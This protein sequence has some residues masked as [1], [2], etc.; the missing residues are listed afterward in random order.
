HRAMAK[1]D[2]IEQAQKWGADNKRA[3]DLAHNW[4]ANISFKRLGGV[5][6]VERMSGLP[7]G[8]FAPQCQ[9]APNT[10]SYGAN[11]AQSVVGFYDDNCATCTFRKPVG[12]PNLLTLVTERDERRRQREAKEERETKERA[13]ALAARDAARKKIRAGLT[14]E[15]ALTPDL[16]AELDGDRDKD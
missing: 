7:I 16:I 11:L 13:D 6:L 10:Q 14:K 5:G 3:M 2:R 12:I 15:A 9:H 8:H 1:D 4:C